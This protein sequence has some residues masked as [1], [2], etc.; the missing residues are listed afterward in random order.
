MRLST[1]CSLPLLSFNI[2]CSN[3]VIG[4]RLPVYMCVSAGGWTTTATKIENDTQCQV[5]IVR[6]QRLIRS[7]SKKHI[8]LFLNSYGHWHDTSSVAESSRV[9]KELS[10]SSSR[11]YNHEYIIVHKIFPILKIVHTRLD[12]SFIH[13]PL[14]YINLKTEHQFNTS[15]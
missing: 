2:I 12:V 3:A 9:T 7:H 5:I 15:V 6:S 4:R 1:T 13:L 11:W 8:V 14:L 10:C